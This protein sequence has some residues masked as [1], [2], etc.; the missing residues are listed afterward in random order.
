[1]KIIF[2][3]PIELLR[4]CPPAYLEWARLYSCYSG[5]PDDSY[6]CNTNTVNSF[7]CPIET[8]RTMSLFP[9][10]RTGVFSTRSELCSVSLEICLCRTLL[11]TYLRFI[12]S[13]DRLQMRCDWKM[14]S[15]C[16][17]CDS[18]VLHRTGCSSPQPQLIR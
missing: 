14:F 3:T 10:A 2:C 4:E 18:A 13:A 6:Q 9:G 5:T 1:M 12:E 11:S 7:R 16:C 15:S 17:P 8:N